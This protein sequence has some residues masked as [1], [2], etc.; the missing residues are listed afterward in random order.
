MAKYTEVKGTT[1][2]KFSTDP[3]EPLLGEIWFNSTSGAL[4][5]YKD[6]PLAWATG[7]NLNSAHIQYGAAGSG[8]LTSGLIFGGYFMI[9]T[10]SYNGSSWTEVND[11]NFPGR[12]AAA[13]QGV[14]G[15]GTQTAALAISGYGGPFFGSS[16]LNTNENWNGT[17]WSEDSDLNSARYDGSAAGTQ[18][19]S[20]VF[21]G[22]V[23]SG[24]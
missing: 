17:N 23:L 19:S 1:I 12:L 15:V 16:Q 6:L 10:E 9:E 8:T 24:G 11:L 7:G 4:T 22:M 13:S 2:R 18:T 3:P 5:G 20:I 21:G 14:Q